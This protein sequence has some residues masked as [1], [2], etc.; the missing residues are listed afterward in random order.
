MNKCDKAQKQQRR[1]AARR[2][3]SIEFSKAIL[4]VSSVFASVVSV[5]TMA[6]VAYTQ[7]TS[8]LEYLIAAVFAE[9]TAATGFYFWKA[10][11]E[12]KIKLRKMYGADIYESSGAGED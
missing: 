5:F 6:M 11:A 8:I 12:N 9:V 1:N 4:L 10:K 7:D 2:K 3:K